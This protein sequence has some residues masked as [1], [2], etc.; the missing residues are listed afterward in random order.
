MNKEKTIEMKSVPCHTCGAEVTEVRSVRL[1]FLPDHKLIDVV[2]E[3][4]LVSKE[5]IDLGDRRWSGPNDPAYVHFR[6]NVKSQRTFICQDCYRAL[7]TL[8]GL[9]EIA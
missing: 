5:V 2:H 3:P 7:D 6:K 9:T 4:G 8:D 1:Q